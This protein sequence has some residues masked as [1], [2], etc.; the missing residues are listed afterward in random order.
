MNI[1]ISTNRL[2]PAQAMHG[3]PLPQPLVP[4]KDSDKPA[5]SEYAK[6]H[7]SGVRVDKYT[8]ADLLC[9]EKSERLLFAIH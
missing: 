6:K 2:I 7:W 9:P 1:F 3:M 8:D 5:R 4:S